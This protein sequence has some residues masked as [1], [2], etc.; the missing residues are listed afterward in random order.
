VEATASHNL[1]TAPE[2]RHSIAD[3]LALVDRLRRIAYDRSLAAADAMREIR[4]EFGVHDGKDPRRR[5]VIRAWTA[6]HRYLVPVVAWLA[7]LPVLG[8]VSDR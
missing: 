4:D 8:I 7:M 2:P 3:V 5:P 6:R 1:A